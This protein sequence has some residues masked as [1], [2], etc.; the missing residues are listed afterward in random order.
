[1]NWKS[2]KDYIRDES[3]LDRDDIFKVDTKSTFSFFNV[4][5]KNREIIFSTIHQNNYKKREVRIEVSSEPSSSRS[6]SKFSK[7]GKKKQGKRERRKGGKQ[8]KGD[9]NF[10][11]FF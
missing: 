5:T 10:Q 1:M 8:K 11:G 3:G 6:K 7:T 9:R 4:D 2:L